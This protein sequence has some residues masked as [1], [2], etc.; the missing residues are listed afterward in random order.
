MMHESFE[1]EKL[2]KLI[3]DKKKYLGTLKNET[4]AKHL[5]HEILFLE[6]EILP[7]ILTNTVILYD[8]V[9]KYC[10]RCYDEAVNFGGDSK[11]RCNGLLVY[12]PV[13]S[14]Y[15][16]RPLIA[17]ANCRKPKVEETFGEGLVEIYPSQIE[18]HNMDGSGVYNLECFTIDVGES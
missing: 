16:E 7:S 4:A 2:R 11:L 9:M 17:V 3:E 10:I 8:E 14:E 18:I 13:H 12:L 15:I 6:R 1:S 5:Q